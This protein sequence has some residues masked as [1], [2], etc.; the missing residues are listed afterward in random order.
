[1]DGGEEG[2]GTGP[3]EKVCITSNLNFESNLLI[4]V[5]WASR[6]TFPSGGKSFP[7]GLLMQR[8][9]DPAP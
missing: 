5:H 9:W 6:T 1:M 7:Q 4:P 8:P 2:L 3:K